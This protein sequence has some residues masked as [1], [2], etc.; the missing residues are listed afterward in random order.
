MNEHAS[1]I[2]DHERCLQE[3]L[4]EGFPLPAE[5]A[6]LAFRDPKRDREITLLFPSRG[7]AEARARRTP[8]GKTASRIRVL[9][10]EE[11]VA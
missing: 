1:Y 10:L 5:T 4:E 2:G 7:A 8:G 9:T 11:A 6:V 3:L